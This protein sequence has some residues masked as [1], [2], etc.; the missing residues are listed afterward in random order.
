MT[1]LEQIDSSGWN[2]QQVDR[3]RQSIR[4]QVH[5]VRTIEGIRPDL[6]EQ[7]LT[8][9]EAV[10]RRLE[11]ADLVQGSA[12]LFNQNPALLSVRGNDWQAEQDALERERRDVVAQF[13]RQGA[14][15]QLI[16]LADHAA[17]PWSVGY[18]IG[19]S[20]LTDELVG[21][22]LANCLRSEG[23]KRSQCAQGI[24]RGRFCRH[25]WVWVERFFSADN[26]NAVSS[27]SKAT[28]AFALPFETTVWNWVE[29]WG[30]DV[31]SEYWRSTRVGWFPDG[32][33][34]A[35]RAIQ[36]L[37]DRGRPFAAFQMARLC[38]SGDRAVRPELLLAVLRAVTAVARG[39]IQTA[40][41]LRM[42][43]G[44]GYHLSEVL[45]AL[46]GAAVAEEQELAQIE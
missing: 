18:Y 36:T 22:L 39:E 11:P 37:L 6:S 14:V 42:D 33:R 35:P 34:D 43:D 44:F 29:A 10:Y 2:E 28:F 19:H 25:G 15:D 7:Q 46:E 3:L 24:I 12:W 45:D 40:E 38:T 30:E 31:A 27:I 26:P 41:E 20:D 32:L 21:G 17:E 8:K 4:H 5:L 16:R 1:S 23:E 9:L 13:V